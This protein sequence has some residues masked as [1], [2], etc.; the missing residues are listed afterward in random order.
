[1][2]LEVVV[3]AALCAEELLG[4]EDGGAVSQTEHARAAD[5]CKH[6]HNRF[7]SMLQQLA[8]YSTQAQITYKEA[9]T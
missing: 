8:Q 3:A 7:V 1:M 9:A 2:V 4:E 5:T 6:T